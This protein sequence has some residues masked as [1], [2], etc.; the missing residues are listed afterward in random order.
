[1]VHS[2]FYLSISN[3]TFSSYSRSRAFPTFS[4]Q[5]CFCLAVELYFAGQVNNSCV[6]RLS[7]DSRCEVPEACL[8]AANLK[9]ELAMIRI[10]TIARIGQR[11]FAGRHFLNL[12]ACPIFNQY[13]S[14]SCNSDFGN[15]VSA[16]FFLVFEIG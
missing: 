13:C 1:M 4:F 3:R 16:R 12:C 14:F 10:Y 7:F 2:F 11:C 6:V 5:L 8:F 15:W 9:M